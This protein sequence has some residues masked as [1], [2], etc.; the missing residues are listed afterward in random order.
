IEQVVAEF[1]QNLL[2]HFGHQPTEGQ[3]K[4]FHAFTRFAFS[5][6]SRCALLVKGYAGTGKTTCV[7][8]MVRALEQAGKGVV[9]LAPTGRAAKVLG[10]YSGRKAWTIH[11]HIYIRKND[12]SGNGW[13]ELRDNELENTVFFVDD[14]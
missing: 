7:S 3:E 4:L 8:T 6:K 10:N 14:A 9:L 1:E 5:E 12:R 11:K 13:F 2:R